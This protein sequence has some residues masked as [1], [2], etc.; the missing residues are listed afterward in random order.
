M[1]KHRTKERINT[2]SRDEKKFPSK[3]GPVLV[4]VNE[5]QPTIAQHESE[6]KKTDCHKSSSFDVSQ[7]LLRQKGGAGQTVV[8]I[9]E[10][11]FF[12]FPKFA[13]QFSQM[14]WQ[15]FLSISPA[16]VPNSYAARG[17]QTR[18]SRVAPH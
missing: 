6:R 11:L 5:D 7:L 18:V 15:G 3:R 13:L 9:G 14:A 10:G 16:M 1:Y 8:R 4:S 12:S 2:G 17:I